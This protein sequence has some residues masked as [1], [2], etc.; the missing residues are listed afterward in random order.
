MPPAAEL[1]MVDPGRPEPE[2]WVERRQRSDHPQLLA[3]AMAQREQKQFD[4]RSQS[5]AGAGASARDHADHLLRYHGQ[6]IPNRR[7]IARVPKLDESLA[8]ELAPEKRT[9]AG[10]G[11]AKHRVRSDVPP[12]QERISESL[13]DHTGVDIG[14]FGRHARAAPIAPMS[15]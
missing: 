14:A 12:E 10:P 7:T 3:A 4:I 11:Q 6:K 5:F 1:H 13:A 9:N 2:R 8:F 15:E